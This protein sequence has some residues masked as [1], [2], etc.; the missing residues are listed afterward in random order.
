MLF[1]YLIAAASVVLLPVIASYAY[2]N[3]KTGVPTFPTMPPM[4][5]KMIEI[6]QKDA[7]T[8][9]SRPY[10]IIDLGSG[11]GQLS[12]HIA[13]SMPQ[14]RVIGIEVS[15]VPWLRSVIHRRLFGPSNVEYKRVD[16]WS[17]NVGHADAVVTYLME[18]LMER[19]SEKLRKELKTGAIVVAS[20]FALR[21]GWKP[22][23]TYDIGLPLPMRLSLYRQFLAANRNDGKDTAFGQDEAPREPAL[24][25]AE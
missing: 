11:S 18:S 4:R 6:L 7:E 23:K 16:F 21:A 10:T 2:Y 8:R 15:Y 12:R 22:Y 25:V 20:K 3:F 14:A 13:R 24:A 5:K 17:Y 9:S 19:V 1:W